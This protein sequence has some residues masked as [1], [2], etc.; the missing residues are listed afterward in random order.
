M[1]RSDKRFD[2]SLFAASGGSGLI[3]ELQDN[4]QRIRLLQAH[5]LGLIADLERDGI[6]TLGRVF[7]APG[8]V[9][10]AIRVAP[11]QATRL[12]ARAAQVTETLTPTGYTM[13]APCPTFGR[14]A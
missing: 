3:A 5:Q 1:A 9:I 11:L 4:A 2:E 8:L 7:P 6:A 14:A 10:E 13:P 12:V